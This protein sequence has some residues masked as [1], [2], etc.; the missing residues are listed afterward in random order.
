MTAPLSENGIIL[1]AGILSIA[2]LFFIL[3]LLVAYF[4]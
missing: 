2:C 1:S 4:S 3:L